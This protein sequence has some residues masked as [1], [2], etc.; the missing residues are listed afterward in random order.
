MLLDFTTFPCSFSVSDNLSSSSLSHF[1][2]GSCTLI[3]TCHP[4]DLD[5]PVF[6]Y[7]LRVR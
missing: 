2:L 3:G 7:Q 4:S 1:D 6:G 5:M